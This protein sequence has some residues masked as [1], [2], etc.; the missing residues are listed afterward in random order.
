MFTD[1]GV[2]SEL[3][4]SVGLN[5]I[6]CSLIVAKVVALREREG[7]STNIDRCLPKLRC[8]AILT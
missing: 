7:S 2:N 1:G 4:G 6:V 8:C 3:S 5:Y